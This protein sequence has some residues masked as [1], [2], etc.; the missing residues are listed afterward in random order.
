M[1]RYSDAELAIPSRWFTGKQ[2]ADGTAE[3]EFK[4]EYHQ[5]V[6]EQRRKEPNKS[7]R[8]LRW[9]RNNQYFEGWFAHSLSE[10]DKEI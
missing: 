3:R 6:H 5:T 2:W 9:E 4:K 1:R 7:K 10:D 8:Q